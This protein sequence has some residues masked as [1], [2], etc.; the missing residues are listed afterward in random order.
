MLIMH[1]S[2]ASS[3][4]TAQPT[5]VPTN[6]GGRPASFT[7]APPDRELGINELLLDGQTH[8]AA[9]KAELSDHIHREISKFDLTCDGNADNR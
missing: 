7:E 1:F 2:A 5:T 9:L 3:G 6:H 4:Q 8:E